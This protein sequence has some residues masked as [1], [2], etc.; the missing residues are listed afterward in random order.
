MSRPGRL[1][2]PTFSIQRRVWRCGRQR[3]WGSVLTALRSFHPATTFRFRRVFATSVATRPRA[4]EPRASRD[5]FRC[6]PPLSRTRRCYRRARADVGSSFWGLAPPASRLRVLSRPRLGLGTK[7][8]SIHANRYCLGLFLFQVSRPSNPG[9]PL[10]G[11]IRSWTLSSRRT[12]CCATAFDDAF[13]TAMPPI[14]PADVKLP[15]SV[16]MSSTACPSRRCS[17]AGRSTRMRFRTV[18]ETPAGPYSPGSEA[19]PL[20]PGAICLELPL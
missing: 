12:A 15:F 10:L 8:R 6:S 7:G 20:R 18:R 13:T 17:R 9:S 4:V 14:P 5:V 2:R 19:R 16:L 1:H 11:P 3:S